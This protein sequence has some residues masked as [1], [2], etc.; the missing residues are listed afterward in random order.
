MLPAMIAS[1][2]GR[3][4]IGEAAAT[5]TGARAA[6]TAAG[7]DV[8]AQEK[9]TK[10]L[11]KSQGIFSPEAAKA[12]RDLETFAKDAKFLGDAAAKADARVKGLQAGTTAMTVGMLS[13]DRATHGFMGHFVGM[14]DAMAHTVDHLAGPVRDFV[15]LA[16]PAKAQMFDLA[17]KD[18]HAVVGRELIPVLDAFTRTARI[19]GDTMAGFEPVVEPAVRAVAELV[20]DIGTGLR[21]AAVECEPEI[22]LLTEAIVVM[23]KEAGFWARNLGGLASLNFGVLNAL[24]KATGGP[25]EGRKFDPTRTSRGAAAQEARFVGAKTIADEAIRSALTLGATTE[26]KQLT[27]L[28]K[29]AKSTADMAE[30]MKQLKKDADKSPLTVQGGDDK[31]FAAALERA[32]RRTQ[33]TWKN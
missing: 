9:L 24:D 11:V 22:R 5:A 1:F 23:A 33:T 27:E 16:N 10:G 20:D 14:L 31:E 25:P 17:I 8:K 15:A 18:A 12:S 7:A 6:A 29:I 28:E 21:E 26:Q 32:N 2:L 13:A 19:A 4:A 3:M 30:F